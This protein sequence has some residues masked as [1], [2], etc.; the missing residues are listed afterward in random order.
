MVASLNIHDNFSNRMAQLEQCLI[1]ISA[2][3]TVD[4][5]VVAYHGCNGWQRIR[6]RFRK[7]SLRNGYHI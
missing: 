1:Q 3:S 2:L 7:G 4:R 5:N 6:V